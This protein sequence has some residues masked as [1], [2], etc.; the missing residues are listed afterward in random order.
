MAESDRIADALRYQQQMSEAIPMEGRATFLPF[1]DTLPGSV[2]NKREWALPGIVAGAVNAF[3]APG[4]AYSG[5]DPMFDPQEEAANFAMNV[6]GGGMAIGKAPA[7]S[8]GM[9]VTSKG[10]IPETGVDTRKLA[11]MLERAGVKG[12]YEIAREGS[13]VSP[14]QYITFRNPAD[15]LATR[16]V[17]IS[18][19]ADKYPELASGVRTSVDPATEVS[20]EQAVNWLAKEG[21]PTS[22]SK[23]Y[24]NIPSWEQHYFQQQAARDAN[25][26]QG[27]IDAWRNKPKATRGPIPTEYDLLVKGNK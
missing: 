4:R 26:L 2:M 7:G 10:R 9:N 19:H 23:K 17:R 12:G 15:E 20:F 18:N 25:K 27:L 24:K 22:L 13:A 14:S 16:Q 6:M 8:L 21:Y 5:S 11:D 3:T 1:K